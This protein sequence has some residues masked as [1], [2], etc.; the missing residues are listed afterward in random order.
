MGELLGLALKLYFGNFAVFTLITIVA[1]AP[2][3]IVQLIGNGLNLAQ[4]LGGSGTGVSGVALGGVCAGLL[5]LALSLLY[6]LMEGA[7]AHNTI[8]RVLGR[9]PGVRE[10]YRAARPLWSALWGSG[11]ARQI[12]VGAVFGVVGLLSGIGNLFVFNSG[13]FG[14]SVDGTLGTVI[15][16]VTAAICAPLGLVALIFGIRLA[17]NWSLRAPVAVGESVGAFSALARSNT[18]VTRDRWRM[19][20]RLLPVALL[21]LI[22]VVLPPIALSALITGNVFSAGG[23]SPLP[24]MLPLAS[25]MLVLGALASLLIVPYTLIYLTLNYLDLRTRKENL[26]GQLAAGAASTAVAVAPAMPFDNGLANAG[27]YDAPLTPAQKI[28]LLY[29]RMR[30]DGESAPLLHELGKA[31][32][33]LGSMGA[34]HD[35]LLRAQ[36]LD[37]ASPQI[38]ED[39]ADLNRAMGKPEPSGGPDA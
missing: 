28:A 31:Y 29:T 37:P 34:A 38:A 26:A 23:G 32:L 18:L 11:L 21:D 13:A 7:L 35:A 4:Y 14:L 33:G 27:P 20:A 15:A 30:T 24:W 9:A 12:A 39:L 6:P 19:F 36:A 8:E 1:L 5:G 25:G 16:V 2:I 10:S 3:L 17:I 22:F